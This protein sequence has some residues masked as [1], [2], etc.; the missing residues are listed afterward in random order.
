MKKWIALLL[1]LL[2]AVSLAACSSQD[3][4]DNP[5]LPDGTTAG[6]Q[7][8][9]NTT[10]ATQQPTQN[11]EKLKDFMFPLAKIYCKVPETFGS[12]SEGKVVVATG[13]DEYIATICN[14]SKGSYTGGLEGILPFLAKS[15]ADDTSPFLEPNIKE[16]SLK[17]STTEKVTVSGYEALKFSGPVTN[18]S[19]GTY[20]IY[21]YTMIIDEMPVMFLGVLRSE[22]QADKDLKAMQE[23]VDLM[24]GSIFKK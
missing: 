21:G 13:K 1:V 23:L 18:T 4:P 3:T 9:K 5:S 24:A 20:Q 11:K 8:P 15:Y 12:K 2:M 16:E 10:A 14:A 7:P 19:G 6:N 22:D 17:V